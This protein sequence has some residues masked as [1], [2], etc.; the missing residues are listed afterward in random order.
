M[1]KYLREIE[2]AGIILMI[3]GVAMYRLM[4]MQAGFIAC[5]IGIVL[6][7]VEVVYKAF[8]WQ[9]YRRDNVQNIMMMLVIIVLLLGFMIWIR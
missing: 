1:K 4:G 8:K 6:W 7:L 5:A 3:I 9:E 2:L